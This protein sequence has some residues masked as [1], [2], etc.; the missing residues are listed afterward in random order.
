MF[1]WYDGGGIDVSFLGLAQTDRQGNVNVSRFSGRSVGPGGFINISTA[2]KTLVYCGS[3]TAGGLKV[4]VGDG[5][6]RVVQ[7]GKYHKFLDQVEEI[8][9][10]GAQAAHRGQRVLYVTERAVF[11][12]REGRMTLIEIAP[13]IDLERDVLS[14]M[15]FSPAIAEPL[16]LMPAGIFKET[17][18]Q[19]RAHIIDKQEA[20]AAG[21]L[22]ARRVAAR[23]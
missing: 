12:L 18:G 8:T 19:L 14:L 9:F 10:S 2:T 7:E 3:L 21:T 11:E 23:A 5:R 4:E 13:G 20:A 17:W 6:I 15:D 1:D 16:A 22:K